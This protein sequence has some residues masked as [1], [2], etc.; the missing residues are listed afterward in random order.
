MG[1]EL[2]DRETALSTFLMR[3][4]IGRTHREANLVLLAAGLMVVIVAYLHSINIPTSRESKQQFAK[5]IQ[6]MQSERGG[7]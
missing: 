7:K 5:E 2:F 4:K 3:Y 1:F 6:E